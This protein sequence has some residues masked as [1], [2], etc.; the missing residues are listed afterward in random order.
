MST[1]TIFNVLFRFRFQFRVRHPFT[2]RRMCIIVEIAKKRNNST[3][4]SIKTDMYVLR[5]ARGERDWMVYTGIFC[6]T[7]IAEISMPNQIH[8]RCSKNNNCGVCVLIAIFTC[9]TYMCIV[10]CAMCIYG[11]F[12]VRSNLFER[13]QFYHIMWNA[14]CTHTLSLSKRIC[15]NDNQLKHGTQITHIHTSLAQSN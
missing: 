8:I 15:E 3:S 5:R 6:G 9:S 1:T 12:F 7:N 11:W 10:Q 2:L 13:S 4:K 14:H